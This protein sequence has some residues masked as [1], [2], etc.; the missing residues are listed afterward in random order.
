MRKKIEPGLLKIFRF[1]EILE[2]VV[3][4]M[5]VILLELLNTESQIRPTSHYYLNLIGCLLLIGYLSWPWL[6]RSLKQF[7]LPIALTIATITPILSNR[8]YLQIQLE[9][10]PNLLITN[11][12]ELI[13]LLFIPLVIMAW[14]YNLSFV[15]L[16]S[17]LSGLFDFLLTTAVAVGLHLNMY[18]ILGVIFIRT[19]SLMAVGFLVV[20]LMDTQREQR[21]KLTEANLK[22]SLYANT[23]EQ[24]AVSRERNRLAR[25]LHDTLAHTLSGL[26]VQL[27]ALNT[28]LSPKE[29]EAKIM[30]EHALHTTRSGLMETR[31]ALRA[32]RATQLDDFGLRQALSNLIQNVSE[33]SSLHFTSSLPDAIDSLPPHIEQG[34]YRIAQESLE[35]V[36][37]H[38]NATESSLTISFEGHLFRMRIKDN[39]SGFQ[40]HSAGLND[41]MGLTG[42]HERAAV[43]GG[44]LAITSS[45][46]NGTEIQLEIPD[47]DY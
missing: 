26:A 46:E 36:L 12:W 31:R 11:A 38:S 1:I 45:P 39:G 15:F 35:N 41:R 4:L 23:L 14:N 2:A 27:E 13:P 25:E 8:L 47:Y 24:L 3:L 28:V 33:R 32:L 19:I 29:T 20:Q 44:S 17:M 37:K 16:F 21:H 7:Y 40:I 18:T 42:M 43:L 22:L 30:L 9:Q 6:M 5:L 34:V 10:A